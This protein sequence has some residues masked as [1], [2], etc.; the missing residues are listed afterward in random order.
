M[1]HLLN[2]APELDLVE[3]ITKIFRYGDDAAKIEYRSKVLDAFGKIVH[4]SADEKK[5]L[6]RLLTQSTFTVHLIAGL[7]PTLPDDS[8]AGDRLRPLLRQDRVPRSVKMAVL[9]TLSEINDPNAL[10]S[11]VDA[12]RS[13]DNEMRD[14]AL[15]G[16]ASV[17]PEHQAITA[18]LSKLGSDGRYSGTVQVMHKVASLLCGHFESFNISA[19]EDRH[20]F[21]QKIEP[22][23]R[24]IALYFSDRTVGWSWARSV[25]GQLASPDLADFDL[26]KSP[27]FLR[28]ASGARLGMATGFSPVFH[29]SCSEPFLKLLQSAL[30]SGKDGELVKLVKIGRIDAAFADDSRKNVFKYVPGPRRTE[31]VRSGL[32][33]GR[34][35]A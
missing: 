7:K 5:K 14:I 35:A 16:L 15:Q 6:D 2:H 32:L 34:R 31:W 20:Q 12:L 33:S 8:D 28:R 1:D 9:K 26:T 21:S 23:L 25:R 24:E 3:R 4:G 29:R 19:G 17:A 11:F 18:A 22:H 30:N 27:I 13:T 10:D